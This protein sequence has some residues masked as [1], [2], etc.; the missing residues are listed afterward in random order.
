M[1]DYT[2]PEKTG[3]P[4]ANVL[5]YGLEDGATVIV[6]PSGTEPK[7]KAYYTTLGASL[8]EAQAE[9]DALADAL[10]PIFS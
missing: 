9:K 10:K 7:I 4:K 5:I 6:R 8:D 2:E 3:L 1:T